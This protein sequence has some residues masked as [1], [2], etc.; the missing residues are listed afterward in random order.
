MKIR[1]YKVGILTAV[2]V[3]GMLSGC[4]SKSTENVIYVS[5]DNPL[6]TESKAYFSEAKFMSISLVKRTESEDVDGNTT[7][8]YESYLTSEINLKEDTDETIDYT[9]ALITGELDE[10]KIK[11]IS[12]EDAF[13]IDYAKKSGD[14]VFLSLLEANGINSNLKDVDY[15]EESFDA[16]GR[17]LYELKEDS[18]VLDDLLE[19]VSCDEVKSSKVYYQTT[20]LSDENEIPESITAEVVYRIGDVTYTKTVY[21]EIT[22]FEGEESDEI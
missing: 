19:G 4:G 10:E 22:I 12:F 16:L 6:T 13:G 20:E 2:M 3:V 9:E 14:E 17:K 21:I 18:E 7:V 15:D 11:E 1:K 5:E 8:S